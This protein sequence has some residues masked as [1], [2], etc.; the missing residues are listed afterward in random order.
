MD[1]TIKPIKV[2]V[3]G[4]SFGVW[5]IENEILADA[6]RRFIKLIGVCDIDKAKTAA[7]SEKYSVKSYEQYEDAINDN[8]VEAIVLIT[9]PVGR[10]ALVDKAIN[11]GKAVLTTKP[12]DSSSD[13]TLRVLRKSKELGIPVMMNSPSPQPRGEMQQIEKWVKEYNLGRPIAYRASTWCSYREKPDNSWYDATELCPAAPIY[14][15][16][17]YL[18]NDL[19]RFF[20]P[21]KD[22]Q[23]LSSRIFTERPTA[24]NA[25]LSLLHEDGAIGN[26]FASFCIEDKQYYRCSMEINFER[27]T[28]Y[29]NVGPDKISHENEVSLAISAFYGERRL[30]EETT[31]INTGTGY[32]IELFYKAV[33][34]ERI[35]DIISP[36]QVAS[37]IKVF[38]EMSKIETARPV[39]KPII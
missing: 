3:V 10:A 13:E 33:R 17:V 8:E 27:G 18:L 9:G 35:G 32:P 20:A 4:L 12:F 14:R 5:V 28:I 24:D 7:I 21:V 23:V 6:N 1:Q 29:R 39:F 38:E 19:C 30:L 22:V 34:K 11:S 15:L 25:S 16:G 2:A 26:I 31:I 36:E 37:V